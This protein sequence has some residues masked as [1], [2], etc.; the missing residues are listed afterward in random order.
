MCLDNHLQTDLNTLLNSLF[1]SKIE[2]ALDFVN[3]YRSTQLA[4]G[5]GV[6]KKLGDD[7]LFKIYYDKITKCIEPVLS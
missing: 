6:A 7:D 2:V 3:R 1:N 5:V 4:H